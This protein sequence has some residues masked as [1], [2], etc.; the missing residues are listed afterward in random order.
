MVKITELPSNEQPVSASDQ[1]ILETPAGT[2][3][4]TVENIVGSPSLGEDLSAI[5]VLTGSGYLQRVGA[6]TWALH[7]MTDAGTLQGRS[8][9]ATAPADGQVLKW[10][11]STASWVPG[12]GGGLAD[13]NYT[14]PSGSAVI[15]I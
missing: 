11:A 1:L 8:V 14:P 13:L 4:D 15:F 6:G 5:E 10:S 9:A 7:T 12:A 3:R 2:V